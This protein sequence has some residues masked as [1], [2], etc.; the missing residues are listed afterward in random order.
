MM[1]LRKIRDNGRVDNPVYL[2]SFAVAMRPEA[3][4]FSAD[5]P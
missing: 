1:I 3:G 2:R 4:L 5:D